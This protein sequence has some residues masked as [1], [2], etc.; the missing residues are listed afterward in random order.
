MRNCDLFVFD[1]KDRQ[2]PV[3]MQ[4]LRRCGYEAPAGSQPS[5]MVRQL[6]GHD[7]A[8]LQGALCAYSSIVVLVQNPAVRVV[9]LSQNVIAFSFEQQHS[10]VKSKKFS[11]GT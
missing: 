8:F 3:L 10:I 4:S 9:H 11:F 5:E 1:R 7:E 6:D 2:R